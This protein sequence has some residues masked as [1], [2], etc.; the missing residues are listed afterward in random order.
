MHLQAEEDRRRVAQLEVQ[1]TGV[2]PPPPQWP[3]LSPARDYIPYGGAGG[4]TRI[5]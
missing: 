4:R 5:D 1:I 2:A 3:A